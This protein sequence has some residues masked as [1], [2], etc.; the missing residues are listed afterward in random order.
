MSE[1]IPPPASWKFRLHLSAADLSA[2][3]GNH[4]LLSVKSFL[5]G[6][7][8]VYSAVTVKNEGLGG[9]WNGRITVPNL[10]TTLGNKFRLTALDCW[11]EQR[12]TF[13]AAA[14][15]E[16]PDAIQW[17]WGVDLTASELNTLL[18]KQDGKLISIRAYK[19]KLGG[20][21]LSPALRYCAI[22]V[23]DDGVEWGWI[24]DAIADS[25]TDTL[26]AKFA[27][28]ISIDNLD[29]TTWLG[30]NEHFCAV[31]YKNVTGQVWFW[32]FGLNK[33]QLP[34]EP[35]KFCS[36][37]LDVSYCT[38]DLFVSLMEQFP[39][40]G[41]PNLANLMTF[42]GHG[43]GKFRAETWQDIQWELNEQNLVAEQVNMESAF[44]F[45]AAE[46]G[47]SWWSGNFT[48]PAGQSILG[49]PVSLAA[50]QTYNTSPLWV[51]TNNPKIGLFPIKAT[52]AGGKYQFLLAQARITHP[53]FPT[54]APLPINWPVFLGIQGPVEAVKL[55][56]GK[57]WITVASQII[58]GTGKILDITHVSV[59]V[60]DQ[61][62]VT[63][64]NANFT[65]KLLIDQDALGQPLDPVVFGSVTGSN[66]PLPKFYDG[67]EVPR[68]F[69]KGKVKVQANVKFHDSK[70]AC[71]GDERTLDVNFAPVTVMNRL[72]HD[73]PVINGQ[74]N[75][76]FRW[77]W[78]N[79]I[80]G[81]NFNSHS[82]PEHR[83]SYDV[84][85]FDSNN[86]SFADATKKDQNDNYYC[87]DQPVLAMVSG[88]V[89]FVAH[90][91]E[92]HFGN[93]NNPNSK[94]A[95]MVVVYNDVLD[96]YQLY[97]HF[98]QNSIEVEVGDPVSPGDKLGLIGNSGGSSEPH[99]HVGISRRDNEG[100]LRSLPMTFQKIKD[101]SNKTVSGVPADGGFYS[102]P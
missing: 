62:N 84:V 76:A 50:S 65:D 44:M 67:F 34:K 81:T 59:R 19:T 29:N 24:P 60:K 55:T 3:L 18:N 74:P 91:F 28:L 35:P 93:V 30:D 45:S 68:T 21:L 6:N 40:P 56:N 33:T 16:N 15:V 49:L 96:F 101:G 83:Y 14:W 70:L 43:D 5:D 64:H 8:R 48:D 13:C 41:D 61:N 100:F 2:Q 72:P 25:I 90:D 79:G 73:V 47:W 87:W 94:G 71:Y 88:E 92:D 82:F 97:V 54:P 78:G 86:Q 9:S 46:G 10:K 85:V 31:W 69:K 17:N 58:N 66:A 63:V 23:K 75:S 51:V 26:D 57:N 38:K 102:Q 22:W 98:K 1:L 99:L 39:K 20:K 95:N 27:R 77:H 32:N 7:K 80:G 52:I 89:V 36:W 53:G 42:S 4:R 12:R 11:E 37:G